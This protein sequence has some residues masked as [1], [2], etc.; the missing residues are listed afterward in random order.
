MNVKH[1]SLALWGFRLRIDPDYPI[2][3]RFFP[4]FII[5]T[6]FEYRSYPLVL[7]WA[8]F[9]GHLAPPAMSVFSRWGLLWV[10]I[11]WWANTSRRR[12]F[13]YSSPLEFWRQAWKESPDKPRVVTHFAENVL[14]EIERECKAGKAWSEIQPLIDLGNRLVEDVTQLP[15]AVENSK[16]WERENLSKKI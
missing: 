12:S 6:V 9:L 10:F 11:G 16:R 2:V 7:L 8:V 5:D 14:M 13:F 15:A 4:N 3:T 1:Y